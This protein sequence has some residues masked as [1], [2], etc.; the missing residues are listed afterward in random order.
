MVPFTEV[1][2]FGEGAD[3]RSHRLY[4]QVVVIG[5]PSLKF[6]VDIPV[7]GV[8]LNSFAM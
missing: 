1:G 5:M 8:W 2:N 4:S 7:T 6:L 3:L